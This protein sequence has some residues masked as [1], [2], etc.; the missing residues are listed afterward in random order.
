MGEDRT[1]EPPHNE[2]LN[3]TGRGFLSTVSLAELPIQRRA[4]KV[5]C[6]VRSCIFSMKRSLGPTHWQTR[7]ALESQT[8]SSGPQPKSGVLIPL[9]EGPAFGPGPKPKVAK[10]QVF[11]PDGPPSQGRNKPYARGSIKTAMELASTEPDQCRDSLRDKI[12]SDTAVKPQESRE[13]TWHDLAT[14]AGIQQPFHLDCDTIFTIMGVLDRANYRSAELYLDAAKQRHIEMGL[15]WTQQLA[16]AARQA[17]RACRRGR[18]PAKQAQPLPFKAVA[19]LQDQLDP[20]VN[21]GPCYPV[22]SSLLASW[23]LLREIEA[24]RAETSHVTFD[25]T[26]KLVHWCLPSSKTDIEALGATRTHACCCPPNQ[27]DQVCPYHLMLRQCQFAR[28]H[29]QGP[30]FPTADGDKP[31]KT[32]WAATFEWIAR[33]LG[34]PL[35]TPSGVK[36]FTGHSARATG[37]VHLAMTQ[38]ELWRIQLFGRWGSECFKIYVRSAP[39]S[40]LTHLSQETAV[41]ASLASARAE[42]S[43]VLEKVKTLQHDVAQGPLAQQHVQ[44]LVDCEAAKA[45]IPNQP[46]ATAQSNYPFVLNCSPAGKLHRVVPYSPGTPHHLWHTRCSWYFARHAGDYSLEAAIPEHTITCRKCFKPSPKAHQDS[47]TSSSTSSSSTE[48]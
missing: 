39:L 20:A 45:L 32:G 44:D 8:D 33:R 2:T 38:V 26:Q 15:A 42:L 46:S 30:L 25:E 23:W 37:A 17:R 47:D 21:Q 10:P 43:A 3:F 1:Q 35:L 29:A 5:T 9:V 18:G 22:R 27:E 14:A 19:Q 13:R 28:Q 11:L 6:S 4:T 7:R 16:Q 34:E 36:R 41:S 40:Q 31:L 48:S 24:S 12:R